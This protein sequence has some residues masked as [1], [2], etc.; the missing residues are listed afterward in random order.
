[1]TPAER[2]RS[3]G[4]LLAGELAA[5]TL[6]AEEQADLLNFLVHEKVVLFEAADRSATSQLRFPGLRSD[7]L[8]DALESERRR[9]DAQRQALLA[10]QSSLLAEEIP[11]LLFKTHGPYPY[12]SSNVDALVPMGRLERASAVLRAAGHHEM[13]HYWEPNKRLLRHFR[14]RD[15]DLMIHLHTHVSWIVLPVLDPEAIWQRAR[16]SAD[17][18]IL[19]PA[20]EHLVA[21]LLA[22]AVYESNRVS[23]GDVEKVHGALGAADFDWSLVVAAARAHGWLPGL[24]LARHW[25]ATAESALFGEARL[26]AA[27]CRANLP[28]AP[29]AAR[30]R[31]DGAAVAGHWPLAL[32]R[33]VTKPY[34]FRALAARN[35]ARPLRALLDLAG[36]ALQVAPGRL[37]LR[38]RPAVFVSLC[39]ID[40][41]G[42]STLA[43]AV[44]DALAECELPTRRVW[45]RGGFAPLTRRLKALLRRTSAVPGERDEAAKRAAYRGGR[46]LGLWLAWLA[47]EQTWESLVQV[48]VPRLLG[49]IAVAERYVPDTLIDLAE[50]TNDADFARRAP[51]R[52][53]RALTP[54]PDLIVLLDL[55]GADAFAR[56]SDAW[57]PEIL[58][59]RRALYRRT[60]GDQP[61][62][63]VLDAKRPLAE[64]EDEIVERVLTVAF[65]RIAARNPLFRAPR[66]RWT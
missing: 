14:G 64:L 10:A 22:H 5:K 30:A 38:R 15:C 45:M 52:L 1:M 18:E 28:V 27:A 59:E 48:R 3:A 47:L 43:D 35:R 63:V 62:L 24:A 41:S 7:A 33:R 37:G 11:L 32:P 16:T 19:H 13:T 51:A 58:E 40:G 44:C 21:A 2:A 4:R 56:K 49:R 25:Y 31:I 50:R 54:R 9:C 34:Y 26:D 12:T 57:S 20:P 55:P 17:P 61:G 39:G 29:A 42:K 6:A 53:L 60:L 65:E 8:R 66:D 36:V 46:L 23:A